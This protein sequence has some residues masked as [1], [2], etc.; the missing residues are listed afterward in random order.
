MNIVSS[1]VSVIVP[2][3]NVQH[4]IL[5]CLE[6]IRNQSYSNIEVLLIDD[7][8][9]DGSAS[10]CDS[11]IEK[12]SR[13]K[14]WHVTNGGV[15]KARNIGMAKAQGKYVTFVDSD[16]IIHPRLIEVLLTS[17]EQN[18]ADYSQIDFCDLGNDPIPFRESTLSQTVLPLCG[19]TLVFLSARVWGKMFRLDVIRK[20][21][22]TF[23]EKV[24]IGEDLRFSL[25]Y[26]FLSKKNVFVKQELYFYRKSVGVTAINEQ[27]ASKFSVNDM[28]LCIEALN[29]LEKMLYHITPSKL[30]TELFEKLLFCIEQ[31]L[32]FCQRYISLMPKDQQ[33]EIHKKA[34]VTL[35]PVVLRCSF[36]T[37]K[38]YLLARFPVVQFLYKM[39]NRSRES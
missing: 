21:N 1:Q 27:S 38:G 26:V 14:V 17:C 30:R 28:V 6:S 25:M 16:D 36:T 11:Y 31:Q 12:D 35:W 22:I 39:L 18:H 29:G 7:G 9:T 34:R 32:S 8:S 33:M 4:Y 24:R 3:Y 19:N 13:F 37:I 20:N 10:I 2:V 5:E 23:K 15:S